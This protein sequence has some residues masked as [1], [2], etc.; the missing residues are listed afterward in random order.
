MHCRRWLYYVFPKQEKRK[1]KI[2]KNEDNN[3]TH[4]NIF[5]EIC[6]T[7]NLKNNSSMLFQKYKWQVFVKFID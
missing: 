7:S 2:E 3:V 5:Q 6:L 1:E 4:H